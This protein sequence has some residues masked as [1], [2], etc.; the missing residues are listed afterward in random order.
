[1]V[2]FLLG[3]KINPNTITVIYA[4]AGIVGGILLAIP[5]KA[6]VILAGLIFFSKGILDA[7]DGQYARLSGQTSYTGDKL[8]DYGAHLGALGLQ[9]GLGFFVAHKS[10]HLFF[11]YL[12][13]LV[14]FLYAANF[15]DYCK[16]RMIDDG[17][18]ARAVAA[19]EDNPPVENTPE[20][21]ATDAPNDKALIDRIE[22]S[23]WRP[24]F[25]FVKTLLD[26]RS[27]S[28]DF[29]CLV[30][31]LEMYYPIFISWIFLLLFIA[32]QAGIYALTFYHSVNT[33]WAEARL[34][35]LSEE[36]V[37]SKK[38]A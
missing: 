38:N 5:T 32:K 27:R 10:G 3:T 29:I 22:E 1:M 33:Y 7:T 9:L 8:D 17:S 21:A 18:I 4:L 14:P 24:L 31:I 26:N 12:I 23:R 6:T 19:Q 13:P 36:I 30:L 20:E 35:E 11:Y 37:Q 16:R 28:V 34:D 25:T 2:H 15:I